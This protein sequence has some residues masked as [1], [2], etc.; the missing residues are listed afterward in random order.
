MNIVARMVKEWSEI[1]DFLLFGPRTDMLFKHKSGL[2]LRTEGYQWMKLNKIMTSDKIIKV[3]P[4]G[5]YTVSELDEFKLGKVDQ[6]WVVASKNNSFTDSSLEKLAK[7]RIKLRGD[8]E[9]ESFH[10]YLAI[11]Q[12][13]WII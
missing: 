9:F 12:S 7:N 11:R 3:D 8:P 5:K 6:I 13:C 10:Q 4:K 1:D 2:K